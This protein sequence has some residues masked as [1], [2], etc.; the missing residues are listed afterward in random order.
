[1][2][3][4]F[5][6]VKCLQPDG[7]ITY[8][9]NPTDSDS[10]LFTYL[11]PKLA[12]RNSLRVDQRSFLDIM[13]KRDL[14]DYGKQIVCLFDIWKREGLPKEIETANL[15]NLYLTDKRIYPRCVLPLSD[16]YISLRNKAAW[17]LLQEDH[18][19]DAKRFFFMLVFKFSKLSER[20]N[21]IEEPSGEQDPNVQIYQQA[22]NG[23]WDFIDYLES[24]SYV[25]ACT[26]HSKKRMTRTRLKRV[27]LNWLEDQGTFEEFLAYQVF[28]ITNQRESARIMVFVHFLFAYQTKRTMDV[29]RHPI[30]IVWK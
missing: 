23:L 1:M 21:P 12:E 22:S 20:E 15:L 18:W 16:H 27:W 10:R 9:Q 14:D 17:I 6:L 3:N 2:D 24:N 7:W 26:I 11:F 8:L 4:L 29:H 13:E 5:V 30:K 19:R 28:N 25:V